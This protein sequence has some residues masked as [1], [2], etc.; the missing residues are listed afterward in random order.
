MFFDIKIDG[1]NCTRKARMVT[2]GHKTAVLISR[3]AR[4]HAI[5]V[6]YRRTQ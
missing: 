1:T 5:G 3:F 6:Y 4:E 2:G